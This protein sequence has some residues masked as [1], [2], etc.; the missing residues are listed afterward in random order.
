MNL[1]LYIRQT[2]MYDIHGN[3]IHYYGNNPQ[4]LKIGQGVLTDTGRQ[5][6][7]YGNYMDMTGSVSDLF[8]LKLTWTSERDDN[9]NVVPGAI[10]SGKSSS[11][12]LTFEGEAY[13]LLKAWLIDDISAPLNSVDVKIEHVGCGNYEDY[14]IT[15]KDLSW[16]DD[17]ACTF[18]VTLKQKDEALSC[19]KRTL[20]SDN[21]QQ[22]FQT[23]P[24]NDKKH[25]R[26]SY[27]NEIRPNGLLVFIWWGA[28]VVIFTTLMVMVPLALTINMILGILTFVENVLN[29]IPGVNVDF[30]LPPFIE[31]KDILDAYGQY[32]VESAGCGREHPAPLIRDYI[33][34]VC[35]YCNVKVDGVSAPIFFAEQITIQTSDKN[36]GNSG[37]ITAYNPHYNAC[38]LN[39]PVQRGIRRFNGLNIF[40]RQDPNDTD[41]YIPDNRPYK[42]LDMFLDE[43]KMLYNAEWRVKN[44]TLYFQRRD[45]FTQP[46]GQYIYTTSRPTA[47][48]G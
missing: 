28:S 27:C 9:G 40:N 15:A 19:I 21:W 45:F 3:P 33:K 1:K 20:V 7:N 11:G 2:V 30:D 4:D 12:T 16:C 23:V 17:S 47:P 5:W 10:S 38:Y 46:T 25:P 36:R 24:G 37:V 42:T 18:D 6:K 43:L 14:A 26:F 32:Y 22:W 39:A 44:G 34:N 48:T 8:K 13:K 41:F 29:A 31:S 35:D